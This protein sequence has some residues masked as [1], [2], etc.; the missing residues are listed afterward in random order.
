MLIALYWIHLKMYYGILKNIHVYVC[1]MLC[2]FEKKNFLDHK[3]EQYRC[4]CSFNSPFWFLFDFICLKWL[5]N[6]DKLIRTKF[7]DICFKT[8]FMS[9]FAIS[10]NRNFAEKNHSTNEMK[11][12]SNIKISIFLNPDKRNWQICMCSMCS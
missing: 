12:I 6:V 11:L 8:V 1:S 4:H 10:L 3:F 2:A 7:L 9:F 5:T